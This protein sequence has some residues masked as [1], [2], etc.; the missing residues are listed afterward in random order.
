MPAFGKGP[1]LDRAPRLAL[2]A[3]ALRFI[4]HCRDPFPARFGLSGVIFRIL[5]GL[6]LH[7]ILKI[8]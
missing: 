6:V 5:P 7:R 1:N 4:V 2:E 8:S 3:P